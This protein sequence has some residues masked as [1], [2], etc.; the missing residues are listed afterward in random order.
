MEGRREGKRLD[1]RKKSILFLLLTGGLL[2]LL[3]AWIPVDTH[4]DAAFATYWTQPLWKVLKW[5]YDTW[6]SRILIE[7]ALIPLAVFPNIWRVLNVG[8]ILLFVWCAADLFSVGGGKRFPAM[9][10]LFALLFTVPLYSLHSAGWIT[11]TVNYLWPLSLGLVAMRPAKHFFCGEKC[12]GWEYAV[13]PLCLVYAAN[14]EQMCAILSGVYLLCGVHSLV[15]RKK[16]SA[17]CCVMPGLIVLMLCLIW[18]CPGNRLRL[19]AET[20]RWF[21]E[22]GKLSFLQKLLWGWIGTFQ[23]YMKGGNFLFMLLPGVLLALLATRYERE[24][25]GKIRVF[26]PALFCFCPY[27]YYGLLPLWEY[28]RARGRLLGGIELLRALVYNTQLPG[29]SP[30]TPLQT[31]FQTAVFLTLCVCL[32]VTIFLVHGRSRETL[33]QLLILGAG[34]LSRV[35]VGLSPTFL[36]SGGRTSVYASA[37]VLI[38]VMRNVQIFLQS[39]AGKVART[40]LFLY[41]ALNMILATRLNLLELIRPTAMVP[42]Q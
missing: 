42:G 5:R 13:C 41:F 26:L 7:G 23:H 33:M 10:V 29:F 15:D 20:E 4:D 16:P 35:I 22:F 39:G 30:Y 27:L 9:G 34:L 19:A 1:D 14:L 37:A 32:T 31:G 18:L 40:I 21:P 6:T 2:L 12:A 17:L 24:K 36:A 25:N 3:H 11:T 28:L 8:M 38:V